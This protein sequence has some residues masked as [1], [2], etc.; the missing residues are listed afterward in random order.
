MIKTQYMWKRDKF[1]QLDKECLQIH[2]V[3]MIFN[4]E[5]LKASH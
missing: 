1:P 5:K 3:N 4:D 2:K